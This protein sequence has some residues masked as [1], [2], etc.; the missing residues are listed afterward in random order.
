MD[1]LETPR[2]RV[3][4]AAAEVHLAPPLISRPFPIP[5]NSHSSPYYSHF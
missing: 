3:C 5:P 4:K 1:R 2:P